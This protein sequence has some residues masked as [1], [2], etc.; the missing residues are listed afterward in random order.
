MEHRQGIRIVAHNFKILLV[1]NYRHDNQESMQR[2]ATLMLGALETRGVPVELL[3]PPPVLGRIRKGANGLGKWLGYL[4]KFVLFPRMLRRKLAEHE[5]S[6]RVVVHICDHSNSPFTRA[7]AGVPHIVTVHDLLAVRSALGEFPQN[8]T[9]WTGRV[10]QSMIR[11]GLQRCQFAVCVSEAT[12]R[13]FLRLSGKEEPDTSIVMQALNYPYRRMDTAASTEAL[14]GLFDRQGSAVPED[15]FLHIGGNSW[16]KNRSGVLRAFA[17]IRHADR[18]PAISLVM[19]GT[20]PTSDLKRLAEELDIATCVHWTGKVSNEELQALYSRAEALVFPSLAEGFG[21][22]PLEAQACGCLVVTSN[23]TSLP[24]VAGDGALYMDPE[25]PAEGA[26]V[27]RAL[28]DMTHE[29]KAQLRTLGYR[30]VDRFAV[31]RMVDGYLAAYERVA[32]VP[33]AGAKSFSPQIAQRT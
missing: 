9:R 32:G 15:F 20:P 7:L 8:P 1:G 13:D 28:L 17:T 12:R 30:N 27:L 11:K 4:D 22:P 6:Q 31:D 14:C 16:Y 2:F 18:S 5:H 26:L 19:A 10:L 21:W 3:Y 23:R 25:D 24:E 33:I 29:E